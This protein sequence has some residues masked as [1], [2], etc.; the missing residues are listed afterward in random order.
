MSLAAVLAQPVQHSMLS[1]SVLPS[2]PHGSPCDVVYA[3]DGAPGLRP[4]YR[5]V[6]VALTCAHPRCRENHDGIG[7]GDACVDA[8]ISCGRSDDHDA[9]T[10]PFPFANSFS[11]SSRAITHRGSRV[12]PLHRPACRRKILKIHNSGLYVRFKVLGESLHI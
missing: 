7:D 9:L 6:C 2:P 4:R 11:K 3:C 5:N 8:R 1:C 10:P 12:A